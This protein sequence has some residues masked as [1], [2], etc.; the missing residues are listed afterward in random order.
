MTPDTSTD[1]GKLRNR[2]QRK[3]A[4]TKKSKKKNASARATGMPEKT[5]RRGRDVSQTM[6]RDGSGGDDG[7]NASDIGI[8]IGSSREQSPVRKYTFQIEDPRTHEKAS[9]FGQVAS[10]WEQFYNNRD[11]GNILILISLYWLQGIPLGLAHGSIPFLLKE[12]LSFAQVG[13]FSLA[14]YPYSLKLFWSPFVDS[15]YD[16]KFGRRKSWIV[17]IQLVLG[18][19]FWWM[20]SHI[21]GLVRN[22]AE[23][24]HEI[25]Y[26]FLAIVFLGATQ[27]IAVDG[28]ALTLL[29]K[30]NLSYASTC[31]TVG[32]NCGYFLSFTVFLALNSV[33]FSNKYIFSTPREEGFL[34][35]GPYMAFWAAMYVLV[36]LYL[37]FFKV[38]DETSS[39]GDEADYGIFETYKT[40]WRICKLPHMQQFIMVLFFAKIGF[41]PNDSTTQLKLIERGL[42]REDMA[43]AILI[44]FPVQIFFGYYAARWSQGESK[45]RPWRI[46]FILRLLCGI[47]AMLTVHYFPQD[48]LSTGYFY[49]VLLTNVASSMAKTVQF[50]GVSAFITQIADPVIGGTYMTLLNTLSNFGGTW[51]VFFIMR[52]I[53]Y[54]SSATCVF[55]SSSDADS[56]GNKIGDSVLSGRQSYSCATQE[57]RNRCKVDGGVCNVHWDGYYVVSIACALFAL[58]LFFGFIRPT[59]HRLERLPAHVW[60]VSKEARK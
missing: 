49:V 48:G 14:G 38:E 5:R 22:P 17:P 52:S 51:P 42:H 45:M 10:K 31:Q 55:P 21:D 4:T 16:R 9:L 28:W 15:L 59:V 11:F 7:G 25:M 20:G 19:V 44:D 33:E 32:I 41:I 29:S 47:L 50:V 6:S 56:L 26:L 58:V 30:E 46:A 12:K 18:L 36:T 23:N 35:L 40:I 27:D 3:R 2:K 54:F 43:L 13:L 24:I 1:N 57:D 8:T 53:D 39:S 34:Q 37:V 60:R